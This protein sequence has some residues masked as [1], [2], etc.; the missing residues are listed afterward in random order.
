MNTYIKKELEGLSKKWGVVVEGVTITEIVPPKSV[1]EARHQQEVAEQLKFA[2][3]EDAQAHKAQIIAVREAA[4]NLSDKA[5]AYYY[6]KALE[7]LGEGQ[8]S[9]IIFPMELTELAKAVTGRKETGPGVEALFAKYVPV[10]KQIV[11]GQYAK[12]RK[13]DLE[14]RASKKR[15]AKKKKSK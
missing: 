3:M 6:V 1:Q 2:R 13:L 9:K 7:K 12:D 11:S 8:S 15:N 5:L 4:E 14:R 10:V